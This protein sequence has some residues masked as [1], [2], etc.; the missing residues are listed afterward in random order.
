MLVKIFVENIVE[1]DKDNN[2]FNHILT[3]SKMIIYFLEDGDYMLLDYI[4]D[5]KLRKR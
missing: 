2:I 1:Y 3:I 5:Q 4:G